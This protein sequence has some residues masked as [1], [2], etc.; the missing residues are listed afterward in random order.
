MVGFMF[1]D[2]KNQ[3]V[4]VVI[5]QGTFDSPNSCQIIIF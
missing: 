4:P 2:T 3:F 1:K 5:N